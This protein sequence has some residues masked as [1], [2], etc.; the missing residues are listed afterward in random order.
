MLT[1]T[2]DFIERLGR[3]SSM[4]HQTFHYICVFS[5]V[6]SSV[7]TLVALATSGF[8]PPIPPSWDIERTVQH[9]RDHKEGIRTGASLLFLAGLAYF[10]MAAVVSA[11]MRCIP[12][13]PYAV[14]ALQLA[15]GAA[16]AVFFIVGGL[17]LAIAVFRLDRPSEIT[18]TLND[19]F[20]LS[21]LMPVP[22]FQAQLFALTWAVIV[23]VRP[24][25]L[26]PRYLAVIN[27]V[28]ILL[29]FPMLAMHAFHTG[30][31]AWD[32][33]LGFWV[34]MVI[35]FTQQLVEYIALFRAIRLE[36]NSPELGLAVC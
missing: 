3:A 25:P 5:G 13:V 23:D 8:F 11:Q 17:F 1:A 18:Q 16:V 19:L 34:P 21:F 29:F 10:P 6:L 31:L 32:G 14:I 12:N 15:A 26:F 24:K 20:W 9:Y 33:A 36:N 35:Y 30:P 22:T 27:I 7:F 2:N 4:G 28:I